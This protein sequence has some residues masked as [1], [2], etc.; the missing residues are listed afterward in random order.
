M[1]LNGLTLA[2]IG[3][4]VYE[5][6]VR[7]TLVRSGITKVENLHQQAIMFTSAEGQ[8]KAYEIVFDHLT[9]KERSILKRG[10]NAKTDRRARNASVKDYKQAT[11]FEALIGYLH[12]N[13]E[14]QR[15][16]ELFKLVINN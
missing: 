12:L 6:L 11:G 4:A 16:A 8:S 9:D 15:M 5:V 13:G 1:D 14:Y 7:E 2:Y 10:R 3:D